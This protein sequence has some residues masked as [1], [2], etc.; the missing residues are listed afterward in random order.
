MYITTQ[1]S[2]GM[3]SENGSRLTMGVQLHILIAKH[4][5]ENVAEMIMRLCEEQS[6]ITNDAAIEDSIKNLECL[7]K[8][9][10]QIQVWK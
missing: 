6:R 9:S 1:K 10:S 4:G 8:S 7:I 2:K 3:I 5:L